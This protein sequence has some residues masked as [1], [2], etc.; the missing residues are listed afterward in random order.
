MST[1][2]IVRDDPRDA[3]QQQAM[4]PNVKKCLVFTRNTPIIRSFRK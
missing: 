4:R 1:H 3:T 2:R